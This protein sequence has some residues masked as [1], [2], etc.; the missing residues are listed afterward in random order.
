MSEGFQSLAQGQY[1]LME[2][3]Q[4]DLSAYPQ[5]IQSAL[6]GPASVGMMAPG[7]AGFFMTGNPAF[8]YGTMGVTAGGMSFTEALEQDLPYSTALM[9]GITQGTTEMAFEML[10]A[11]RLMQDLKVGSSFFKTLSAQLLIEIPQEQLTT[12]TQDLNDFMIL[13]SHDDMTFGDYLAAR[14]DAAWHTLIATVTGAGSQISIMYG[15]N[16]ALNKYTDSGIKIDPEIRRMM[17]DELRAK[18]AVQANQTIVELV[19]KIQESNVRPVP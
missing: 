1:D 11:L 7:M 13:P 3:V 5:W 19:S 2:D 8:L 4:G 10:P 16:K 18:E 9:F 14:P 6:Q 12:I 17:E 15:A